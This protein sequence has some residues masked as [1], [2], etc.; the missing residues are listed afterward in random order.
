[1][2]SSPIAATLAAATLALPAGATAAE[3]GCPVT[4]SEPAT[5]ST[6]AGTP[7]PDPDVGPFSGAPQR[8][9]AVS[10]GLEPDGRIAVGVD[11]EDMRRAVRPGFRW[12]YWQVSFAV[13]SRPSER[14]STVEVYYDAVLDEYAAFAYAG[15]SPGR[16]RGEVEVRPG[17]GGGW[18]AR[19]GLDALKL[20]V[21]G[22]LQNV[23]VEAGDFFSY[24]YMNADPADPQTWPSGVYA[25]NW[26]MG[27][28]PAVP[29]I[30]CPGVALAAR[31]LGN[32]RGA[33]LSGDA[34]PA[35]S[36]VALEVREIDGWRALATTTSSTSASYD[37]SAALAPGTYDFRAVAT[38]PSGTAT[39]S[40]VSTATLTD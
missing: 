38:S 16:P 23:A 24:T 17:P 32:G 18:V 30:G 29:L 7:K 20:A 2:R 10:V 28:P 12:T 5:A 15:G 25:P 22:R 3:P 13:A 37:V 40:A 21:G 33:R 4:W 26:T 31:D 27:G 36:A 34:L 11:V 35:G 1:M 8:L 19:F 14:R 6:I 39:T 9:R